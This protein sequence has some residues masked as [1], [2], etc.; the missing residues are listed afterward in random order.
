MDRVRRGQ[1]AV[2]NPEGT[3]K[4]ETPHIVPLSRQAV[5]VLRAL[6]LLTGNGRLVFPGALDKE[7]PMSNNTLAAA[8]SRAAALENAARFPLSPRTAPAIVEKGR[9]SSTLSLG[10]LS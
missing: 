8:C 10:A 2:G 7:R 4:D 3:D 9:S 5:E 6:K 1:I